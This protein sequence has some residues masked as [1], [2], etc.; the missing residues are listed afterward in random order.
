MVPKSKRYRKEKAWDN[1]P[2]LDKWKIPEIKP[3]ESSAFL[4]ESSF[5]VLFPQYREKYIKECYGLVKQKLMESGIKLELNLLE[6][7]LTVRTT[8][9][10]WDP[11][12]IIKARDVIKLLSR[13]VPYAHA[14]RLM[15]DGIF[16]EVV[17][18]RSYVRNTD[19]FIKRRQRLIGPN[20]ATLK[21][22]ELLTD[23]YILVQGSTV[24]IIGNFKNIKILS[25]IIVDT[26]QNIH[27]IYHIKELMI[28][29][30]LMKDEKLK[31]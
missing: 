21:A 24:F 5:A 4:E 2:T 25:R 17:K 9:K 15:D 28:K 10:T 23:C 7:S 11:Y 18:I 6:G 8:K 3:E 31:D 14:L 1:D 30:E 19:R 22:L 13:S 12:A 16:C 27:P 29:R 20:G 26:M